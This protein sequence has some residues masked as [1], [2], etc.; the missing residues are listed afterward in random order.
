M[1][2]LLLLECL[3][4]SLRGLMA[5]RYQK[6]GGEQL[7]VGVFVINGEEDDVDAVEKGMGTSGERTVV[8]VR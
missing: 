7:R 8:K 1:L 3:A 5:H 4:A 2:C 6:R